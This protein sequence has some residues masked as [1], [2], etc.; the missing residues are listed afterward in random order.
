MTVEFSPRLWI[1]AQVAVAMPLSLS[2]LVKLYETQ[3]GLVGPVP[4]QACGSHVL[5]LIAEGFLEGD[6]DDE[7]GLIRLR[8][9]RR[10][11]LALRG[12]CPV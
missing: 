7:G 10:G 6:L 2:Q 5:S 9:S 1:I 3:V 11:E 4:Q 12:R 8:L